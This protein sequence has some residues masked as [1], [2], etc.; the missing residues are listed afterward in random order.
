MTREAL[1]AAFVQLVGKADVTVHFVPGNKASVDHVCTEKEYDKGA[2][3]LV[4]LSPNIGIT[5]GK[6]PAGAVVVPCAKLTPHGHTVYISQ[7]TDVAKRAQSSSEESKGK[8][9]ARFWCISVSPDSAAINTSPSTLSV[10]LSASVEHKQADEGNATE[11]VITVPTLVNKKALAQGD[12]LFRAAD[13]ATAT[14]S[15]PG[16][17]GKSRGKGRSKARA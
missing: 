9:V 14:S 2:L 16:A 1:H 4:P 11:I 8:F 7:K 6:V 12:Q 15:T 17:K 3:V 13:V 5:S 10:K